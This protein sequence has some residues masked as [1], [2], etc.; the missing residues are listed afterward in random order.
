VAIA[1][2]LVYV[3]VAIFAKQI[4]TH[5]P[6]AADFSAILK[7]PSLGHIMGTD[8][9]GR[10]LFSRIVYG[11]RISLYVGFLSVAIGI[12]IGS[13]WGLTAAYLGGTADLISQRI[14]DVAMT[15]PDIVVALLLVSMF[16]SSLNNV[17]IALGIAIVP[18]GARLARG[19]ALGVMPQ[20]YVES[21]VCAGASAPR[22]ISRH[23]LPNVAAPLLIYATGLLGFAIVA[24]ATLAF[25]GLSVP[26][27]DPSWGRMLSGRN[28]AYFEVNPA[29]AIFPGMALAFLVLA[30]NL[31]GDTLR[32]VW[33]PRLRGT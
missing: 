23:L 12:G 16:G 13:V 33:D 6:L 15:I 2:V 8:D 5:D 1:L 17:V 22:I 28:L 30:V 20:P 14:V 32:D 18:R 29:M 7:G 3:V 4:A 19:S 24:E 10:D 31:A 9:I 27:P 11:T 21:A 25:L 26:P